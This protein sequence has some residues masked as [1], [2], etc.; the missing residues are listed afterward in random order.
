MMWVP[1]G[2][3]SACQVIRPAACSSTFPPAQRDVGPGRGVGATPALR[4]D[5][6]LSADGRTPRPWTAHHRAGDAE[7]VMSPITRFDSQIDDI[8]EDAFAVLERH[9]IDG[10]ADCAE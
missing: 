4:R 1:S 9:R 6:P 2:S 7:A 8:A 3:A 10:P 5:H